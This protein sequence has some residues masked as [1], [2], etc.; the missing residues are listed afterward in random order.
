MRAN[1]RTGVAAALL[2]AATGRAQSI[3]INF[4]GPLVSGPSATYPAAGLTGTWNVIEGDNGVEYFHLRRLDNLQ[5]PVWI[6]NIGGTDLVTSNHPLTSGDDQSLMDDYLITYNPNLEVCLFFYDLEDGAYEVISYAWL[7]SQPLVDSY[8]TVDYSG[9]PSAF[10]G[11][12]WRG[13]HELG[14]TYA[15]H[16]VNVVGGSLYSHSG[17]PGGS[18]FTSAALNGVQVRKISP[19]T[20]QDVDGDDDV[21]LADYNAFP[22]CEAGPDKM[23]WRPH[24]PAFDLDGDDD[25]DL[26]DF[27]Q[28][29]STF[30]T[31]A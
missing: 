31:G 19:T 3:N 20:P 29:Q 13:T 27:A 26:R 11:G 28:V 2:A 18:G 17:I 6:R 23:G 15:V 12:Q 14:V 5:S 8:V 22:A 10:V 9:D 4:A 24:C 21:D 7:P 1:I 25:V 16:H 30:G